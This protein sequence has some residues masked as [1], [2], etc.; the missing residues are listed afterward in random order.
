MFTSLV[1]WLCGVIGSLLLVTVVSAADPVTECRF[2]DDPSVLNVQRDFGAVGDGVADDTEALQRGLDASCGVD[3]AATK[4]LYLPNGTYRVTRSLIIKVAVG[5]WLYGESREGVIIRLADDS[6]GVTAVLRTHP[7]ETGP[8]SADWFMRNLRNFTIDVGN[9][10]ETDGIR[11][12][13]TNSGILKNV[14]VIGH[15]KV[16][17]NGG[18]LDQSGPN[19]VQDVEIE[20]F[21]T[22]LL[23]QWI[24]GQTLSR[25][26]IRNCR[27]V[28]VQVSAN[29]VAIEDLVVENT[30]LALHNQ[31]PNDWGH[32]AGVVALINGRFSGNDATQPAILNAG[33]LYLRNVETTGF[34]VAWEEANGTTTAGPHIAEATSGP[35][36]TLFDEATPHGLMLPIEA[37]PEFVWETD[38]NQWV[39]ANDFGATPGDHTDDTAAFQQAMDAAAKTGKS[40]VYFRGIGG[41]DPNWYNVKGSVRVHG[42]V[43]H[44]LGLGFGRI[45]G[46][47]DTGRFVVDDQS[48]PLVKF[49]HID[50]F[51]GT[52]VMLEHRGSTGAMVVESCGVRIRG[53]GRG[54]IFATDCPATVELLEPGQAMWARHFNAEG[55]SDTGLIDNRGGKL[56]ILGMKTEGKGVRI[57]T[58]EQGQTEL[59]GMFA[60]TPGLDENDRRPMFDVDNASFALMGIREICFGGWA[61]H[62]KVR[63]RRGT[64]TREWAEGRD[65]G[66]IGWPLYSGWTDPKATSKP[67]TN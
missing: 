30:P 43:R 26:T 47:G 56:W 9:N 33:R 58:R 17:V 32:W 27:K 39:C 50:A 65:G 24:W 66:W 40:T 12:Y 44:V 61:Y 41:A 29:S 63:E 57:R 48:A 36:H 11:Y 16:G 5:P 10:P 20:G 52:P 14:R 2:P 6:A 64:E 34:R 31:M 13:A 23:S 53:Q 1:R 28:G 51:G 62:V 21:E 42:S 38:P 54:P 37:E 60:Y 18:F 35:A 8:T 3:N 7:N 19:L 4:I 49:Q 25:V 67:P 55:N 45:L 59:F 22:G 15:G 46:E